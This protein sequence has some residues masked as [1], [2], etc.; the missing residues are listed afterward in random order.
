MKNK[1][2]LS[3]LVNNSSGAL[4]HVAGLFTR[5]GY[6]ID[7]L[8]V[9]ETEESNRSIITLVVNEN[10]KK[11]EQIRNQLYKLMDVIFIEDLTDVES[12]ERELVLVTIKAQPNN[13]DAILTLIDVFKA[14]IVDMTDSAVMIEMSGNPRRIQ[15]F[16]QAIREYEIIKLARTGTI[17]LSFP[18]AD[19]NG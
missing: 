5:R 6:N 9:A 7:S 2:I 3:V 8:S 13:R 12:L 17:S 11:V 18:S 15:T 1:H 19:E 4:S 16:I 14:T 10:N